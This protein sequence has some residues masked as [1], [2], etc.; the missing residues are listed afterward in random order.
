MV[1]QRIRKMAMVVRCK[2]KSYPKNP[3]GRS[4]QA[5]T[6]SSTLSHSVQDDLTITET[7][8]VVHRPN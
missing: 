4:N 7:N 6:R 5:E 3:R 8:M 1:A 2:D